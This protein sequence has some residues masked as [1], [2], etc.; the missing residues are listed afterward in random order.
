[1]AAATISET[2]PALSR[3]TPA[4]VR[5]EPQHRPVRSS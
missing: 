4:L 1:V 3:I 2:I 5:L